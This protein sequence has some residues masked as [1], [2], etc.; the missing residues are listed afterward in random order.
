MDVEPQ[1]RRHSGTASFGLRPA[2]Q[3][4]SPR[5]RR[6]IDASCTL[7]ADWLRAP[8]ERCLEAFDQSLYR[9]AERSR[10]HLEQQRC[11]DS[12]TLLDRQRATFAQ[13]FIE[14]LGDSFARLDE[15]ELPADDTP[16]QPL[17]LLD[18]TEHELTTAL[19]KLAAR[20]EAHNGLVLSELGYRF[21]VLVA[22]PPLEGAALPPSP[23]NLAR[24][25]HAA[26]EPMQ[27]PI[28]HRLLL[29]QV[30]E[31]TVTSTLGK[32]YETLNAHLLGD[33]ILPQLRTFSTARAGPAHGGGRAIPAS[34]PAPARETPVVAPAPSTPGA[35]G[36]EPIAILETL[37]DLLARGRTRGS[38]TVGPGRVATADEL[39]VALG[40]LQQHLVQVTDKAS[41]ELRS[42]QR[43]REELLLQLNA[44]KPAGAEPTQLSAEQDD[45]VELVAMLFE[46]LG[47]Q[48]HQ[49]P[50]A[51]ALLGDLQLPMLRLAVA[52][53]DFFDQRE[54]PGR[55]LLGTVAE[56]ANDWL[57]GPDGETDGPLLARLEQ[58]V[59]RA[60]R[61]PPSAGLYTTLLADIEHHLAQLN[62][63]ARTTE[64]RHVE[65][66]QGREKLDQARHR[67]GELMNERFAT[68]Q[69]RG[70]LRALLERAWS[71]VLAL[72][73]LRHG[74]D[75]ETFAWRLRITDQLLG[76][77]PVD[78]PGQ[79]RREVET[80]LQQIGMHAEEAEQV[81]Q[82]LIG[83]PVPVPTAPTPRAGAIAPT[84]DTPPAPDAA[85]QT[86]PT[87]APPKKTSTAATSAAA[88]VAS[89]PTATDT[90]QAAAA[91][92]AARSTTTDHPPS[93][94]DLALRLKHR[95]RLGE[96]RGQESRRRDDTGQPPLGPQEARIHNRL[97]QLPFG[98]WFA[99]AD[100][101]GG[102][103]ATLKLAWFSPV[104]G[105]SLFVTRR[106]QRG[107]EMNLRELARAMAS[108][109]VRELPP[110]RDGLL[111]RAWHALTS[112]L[113][114]PTP[115]ARPTRIGARP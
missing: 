76:Q 26:S 69:P 62:R 5:A 18:R 38:G 48:L 3:S 19:D 100:P 22:M 28:E 17:A 94:T 85:S 60:R 49:G 95:Q 37:R 39:Q 31:Q 55:R 44:D 21:A 11:F 13:G 68:A 29:L 53:H 27:L 103:P 90:G 8:L 6:L 88:A 30:F 71:D 81:A 99:F 45:T 41:R 104:S 87:A 16:L 112:N 63:K 77:L 82:R 15:P 80:G 70:L 66:M 106:G 54:H 92:T 115:S 78:D 61:E 56:A 59:E 10:N 35:G 83:T 25:L 86:S 75:S 1:L 96:Q 7:C 105:N 91:P 4:W 113:L 46:Q 12:R 14:N 50:H 107:E 9:Q 101:A 58:L 2:R 32:L 24:A 89:A 64:R 79:L 34:E 33:G 72:T 73:L 108:G 52:D 74:E 102:A 51:S 40:A 20:G 36:N 84:P 47:R 114:R 43:L 42:A 93:A 97:R 98:T 110:Q 67:A 111:D 65:A 57:D 109:R 23:A